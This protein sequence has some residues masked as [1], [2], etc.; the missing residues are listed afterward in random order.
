MAVLPQGD[1]RRGSSEAAQE[2][3]LRAS[4]GGGGADVK[5]EVHTHDRSGDG[6]RPHRSRTHTART[7][8]LVALQRS[9]K[10]TDQ[11]AKL[12]LDTNVFYNLADRSFDIATFASS[13]DQLFYSPLSVLEIAGK[14]SPEL[15]LRRKAAAQAIL[16]CGAAELPDQDSFLAQTIFKYALRRPTVSLKD[17]VVAMAKSR[18]V[19]ALE[20]GV[21]DRL[22]KVVRKVDSALVG[23]WRGV[24]E[25]MWV[26]DMESIQD[27]EIPRF[28]LWRAERAAGFDPPV[29]KLKGAREREFLEKT[30]EPNWNLTLVSSC[31]ERALL[32][33]RKTQPVVSE[34]E[35]RETITEALKALSCYCGVYTQY[36][37]RLLTGGVL[38]DPN[39]SGD[40]ELF[41]HAIDDAHI[42]V[43]SE[44]KWKN[45][46]EQAGFGQRV[47]LVTR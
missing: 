19:E 1:G 46:A 32:I 9:P 35:T 45:M 11:M 17:A 5:A 21:E 47:Q 22:E 25:G 38:P 33:S 44:R 15:F 20:R 18:S 30:R 43:T 36:L 16:D 29:P 12:I 26:R 14:W 31:H 42:V 6:S 40:I 10:Q 4:G 23:K 3:S 39:D 8:G 24:I 2:T 28:A 34:T 7:P 13:S 41:L 37:I 27:R